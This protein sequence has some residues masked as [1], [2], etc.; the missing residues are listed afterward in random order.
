[1]EGYTNVGNVPNF[2]HL[3]CYEQLEITHW[4]VAE[5]FPEKYQKQVPCIIKVAKL[6]FHQKLSNTLACI[7]QND[8][9]N[10]FCPCSLSKSQ[11]VFEIETISQQPKHRENISKY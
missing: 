8:H 5:L 11:I 10:M 6:F 7:T 3:T 2:M 1:M 4:F 9:I